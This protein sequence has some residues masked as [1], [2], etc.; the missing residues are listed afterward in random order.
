[1]HVGR[2]QGFMEREDRVGKGRVDR[3]RRLRGRKERDTS[4][5]SLEQRFTSRGLAQQVSIQLHMLQRVPFC[6]YRSTECFTV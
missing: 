1:M 2:K 5:W 3:W 4:Q 6:I